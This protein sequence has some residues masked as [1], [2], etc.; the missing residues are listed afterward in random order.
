MGAL[1]VEVSLLESQI[2]Y[3]V[4]KRAEFEARIDEAGSLSGWL[5]ASWETILEWLKSQGWRVVVALLLIFLGIKVSL[6]VLGAVVRWLLKAVED[7]DPDS[8]SAEE[9]RAATIASVAQG[10]LKIAVYAIGLLIALEELGVN[11]APILGSVAILG[12]AISFGSQNLVRDVV[13]GFFILLETQF[14]VGDVVK[15]GGETGTVE[16]INLRSTRLRKYDGTLFIMPNGS[17]SSVANMTRDWARAVVHVGVG[18]G[19]DIARV[20][21]VTSEVGSA[22]MGDEEWDERVLEVPSFV[23]VTELG[24]SAVTVRIVGKVDPGFQWAL[25][26]ELKRRLHVAFEAAGIEIPFPQQVIW[27]RSEASAAAEATST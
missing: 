18:Y 27:H 10:V 14:A 8:T 4:N 19:T 7:D 9:A 16:E 22:I 6:R 24:D 23:G 26:R 3:R 12:L 21:A 25:E 15:I 2:S 5:E 17:I 1:S 13:N 20:E 11:T